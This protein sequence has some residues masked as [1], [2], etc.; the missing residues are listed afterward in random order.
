MCR[1][2]NIYISNEKKKNRCTDTHPSIRRERLIQAS[3]VGYTR[4]L[5]IDSSRHLDRET[6]QASEKISVVQASGDECIQASGNESSR[7]LRDAGIWEH[8]HLGMIHPG[9][10]VMQA[11]G[12]TGIW[13]MI[14]PGICVMQA[15]VSTGIW[16]CSSRHLHN[17]GQA[18]GNVHPGI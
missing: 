16:E 3:G 14:H 9:I 11:S 2:E 13:G 10:C 18:S 6:H 4:H 17:A 5:E 8:R 15:S 12:N 7:H 1:R